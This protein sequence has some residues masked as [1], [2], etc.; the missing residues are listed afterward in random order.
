MQTDTVLQ[1]VE[2]ILQNMS[3]ESQPE[4][5]P[6]LNQALLEIFNWQASGE[7]G[8]PSETGA[9]NQ[10]PEADEAWMASLRQNL[11]TLGVPR[12][13]AVT[14]VRNDKSAGQMLADI[15]QYLTEYLGKMQ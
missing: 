7:T 8:N 13:D 14:L 1:S 12:E 10:N 6:R 4:Q 3:A 11:E 2:N 9:V 15:T 5:L